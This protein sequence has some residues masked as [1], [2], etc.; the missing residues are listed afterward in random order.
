MAWADPGKILSVARKAAA[1]TQ[2]GVWVCGS[3][4]RC[5]RNIQLSLKF[6]L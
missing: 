4:F 2:Q 6:I 3:F 1:A 5:D